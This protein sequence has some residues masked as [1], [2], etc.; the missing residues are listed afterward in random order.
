VTPTE[1]SI[2]LFKR[3]GQPTELHLIAD[4][5]HFMWGEQN[6]RVI[7]LVRDWLDRYFPVRAGATAG[8]A[9]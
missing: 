6:P 8:A 2:E 7:H 5:D 9:S 3:A 1:E 4:V